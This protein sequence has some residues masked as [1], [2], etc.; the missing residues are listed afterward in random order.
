MTYTGENMRS[1][2]RN[3]GFSLIELMIVVTVILVI[4][5]IAIPSLT[6]AKMA[7][8]EAAAASALRT[9]A[10]EEANY[11]AAWS[12]GFSPTLGA[13]GPPP[14]GNVAS[15]AFAD[16]VD[17]VLASGIRGGYQFIYTPVIPPGSAGIPTGYQVNANPISPGITGEWFYFLDQS[18]VIRQNYGS[19]A[20]QNSPPIPR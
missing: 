14:P 17:A 11:D 3:S 16:M 19:P 8:N 18:N 12:S 6:H 9:L 10:T 15:P 1:S 7:A 5:A 20:D 13:L 2:R 4:A